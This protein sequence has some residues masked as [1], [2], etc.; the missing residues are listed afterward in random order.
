MPCLPLA[1]LRRNQQRVK[2]AANEDRN[3]HSWN[4]RSNPDRNLGCW[5]T[6]RI[7]RRVSQQGRRPTRV[8]R[9]GEFM[10]HIFY[11]TLA[12]AGFVGIGGLP[13][14]RWGTGKVR[15][16]NRKRNARRSHSLT[17]KFA[18]QS[19]ESLGFSDRECRFILAVLIGWF[20]QPGVS[21]SMSEEF[22]TAMNL[23]MR[24]GF[25]E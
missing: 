23:A 16:K 12:L 24:G 19:P 22:A 5:S 18:F 6:R 17:P 11:A 7:D 20:R 15:Q 25:D 9:K 14:L 8:I 21:R 1:S 10:T 13:L 2:G 4:R 3:D